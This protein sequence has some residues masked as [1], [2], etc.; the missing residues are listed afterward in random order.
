MIRVSLQQLATVL[1]AQLIGENIDIEDVSTDT[2]KLSSG[3]LFVALKGEKFD[4]HDY[5]A[6]AVKGGA[7]ALL[8]SK[9]LLVDEPQLLVSDTRVA[10]G[11]LAAWV[12]QQSTARVVALTGSSGKTSVKRDDGG[13]SAPVWLR[14]VYRR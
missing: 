4:A 7:A 10:L 3:C 1:N 12:R 9:R 13:D 2:R 14:V 5:A 6:D 11:Q 8:V